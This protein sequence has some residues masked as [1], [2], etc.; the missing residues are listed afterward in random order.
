MTFR[1]I[2]FWL[3]LLAGLI[4][5]LA[6]AI[7]C[8][9]GT[10][11]AFEKQLVA[12]ADRDA[13][14]VVVPSMDAP[15]LTI[16]D[17]TRRVIDANPAAA[18]TAIVLSADPGT[19]VAY[20]LSRD[21]VV[22]ADPYTGEIRRPSTTT[23]RDFMRRME[24]WHRWLA[25][26]GQQRPIGQAI[27]RSCNAAFLILAVSGLYLWL[28]RRRSWS[29][30]RAVALLNPTLSG[31]AR[32]FNWHNAIGLWCA[33]VLIVLTVTALP[34]SFRWANNLI[35]Q[36]AGE[37]PPTP[38]GSAGSGPTS[39]RYPAPPDGTRP[40][41]REAVF[42]AVKKASPAWTQI[43]LRLAAPG[44]GS[45]GAR[46]P[47]TPEPSGED[48]LRP[49]LPE[50]LTFAIATSGSW[51]R[52]ATTTALVN[53][54]TSEFIRHETFRSQT[55]GRQLRIWTR[56]LHT[57]EALGWIGQLIAG[58]ASIGGC[59]LV[60]TGFALAWRRFFRR[61]AAATTAAGP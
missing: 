5:G 47:S 28:P 33:P 49:R 9:T 1:R 2:I 32:D 6:I 60:Y 21:R 22:Y 44:R 43:T 57:G 26:P 8:F 55:A 4:G 19:A 42:T 38:P 12:W 36:F 24:N 58:A 29:N 50:P 20:S 41:A 39:P 31:K 17:L 53:P 46:V 16:D 30:L 7:M 34:L 35:Y 54:F 25:L 14:T 61:Q 59:S 18:P 56:F 10:M 3:H 13:R 23:I 11:L 15:R 40:L 37:P 51:P 45:A 52:T 27:N 48:R